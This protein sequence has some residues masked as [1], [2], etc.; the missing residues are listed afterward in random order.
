MTDTAT[1]FLAAFND[2]EAHFR[3]TLK[4]RNSD[5]FTWLV[6]QAAGRKLL[7]PAQSEL[8]QEMAELRNAIAHGSYEDGE[9][10]ADPRPSTVTQLRAVRD[11][12]LRPTRAMDI[13]G[14]REVLVLAPDSL[15]NDA[16]LLLR[17]EHID[18]FPIYQGR[19]FVGVLTS[20]AIARWVAHDLGD[21]GHL[22][23]ATVSAALE[24]VQPKEEIAFFSREVA[25]TE[26]V[27]TLLQPGGPRFGLITEHGKRDER[28]LRTVS[29]GDVAQLHAELS[30]GSNP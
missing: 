24:H 3:T 25:A 6:R 5:G 13:L 18:H 15:I 2:V 11:E 12:L 7:S 22:D 27:R 30:V 4:A 19:R 14:I 8:L 26:V 23:A 16:L 21:N 20:T 10:L 9:P 29:F 17:D 1:E 28:P